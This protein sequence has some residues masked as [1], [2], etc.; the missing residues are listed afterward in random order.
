MT[1]TTDCGCCAGVT[2]ET[3]VGKTNPPGQ[4][5]IG[6]RAG[7]WSTFRRTMLSRLSS[8]DYPALAPLT[9]RSDDDYTIA[10]CDA[11]AMLADVLTFYQERI[12]NENYLRTATQRNSIVQLADLIGYQPSPGV[13]ASV[14]LAFTL[15]STPGS[16]TQA[17]QPSPVPVGTRAQSV[18]DPGQSA[19][20]FE[21]I[22]AITARVE[23]NAIPAQI[24]VAYGPAQ[25]LSDLYLT[26]TAT[27]LNPGDAIVIVG[28][29]RTPPARPARGGM[30]AGWRPSQPT[31]P[32]T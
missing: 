14:S 7:T 5:A 9:T 23:W 1:G 12:A 3:P 8:S 27:Q 25:N 32:T 11:F 13:A 15:Q 4:P 28:G 20:T 22:G 31:R 17:T 6:Y 24:N 18:P 10:L 2:T 16:P 30:C 21:T 26:G 19:Q 29:E